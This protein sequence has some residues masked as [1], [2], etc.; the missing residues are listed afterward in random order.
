MNVYGLTGF[1]DV[2]LENISSGQA[3][4]LAIAAAMCA[5]PSILLM[6]EPLA[7]LDRDAV[8]EILHLVVSLREAGVLIIIAEHHTAALE[9]CEPTWFTVDSGEVSP[10]KWQDSTA[11][12]PARTLQVVGSEQVLSVSALQ[13]TQSEQTLAQ[14]VTFTG[15]T[16]DLIAITGANGVGKSSLLSE[17]SHPTTAGT[18]LVSSTDIS[19]LTPVERVSRIAHVPEDVASLFTRDSLA[20]ELA[21]ADALAGIP[22]NTHLTSLTLRSLL[23]WGE[24]IPAS[25]LHA[26]PRDLSAGTQLALAISL[27]LSWKPAVITIDEPTRGLDPQARE[28]LAEVLRCV[29]ETGTVVIFATHDVEFSASV[30]AR[31]FVLHEGILS[32]APRVIA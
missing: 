31:Q 14:D 25:L 23:G 6:D 27:Q 29:A 1:A 3:T 9:E 20:E 16:A 12:L 7:D 15:N 5:S 13:V 22:A 24:E 17:L 10:G 26:H 19:T 21:Y 32:E 11:P 30:N 8:A 2:P 18:V 4:R 28:L